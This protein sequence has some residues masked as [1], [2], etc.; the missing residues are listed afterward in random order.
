MFPIKKII[1]SGEDFLFSGDI[2]RFF[3]A[4]FDRTFYNLVLRIS[5]SILLFN[6]IDIIKR[7]EKKKEMQN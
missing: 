2:S 7:R 5:I 4:N 1:F 3:V 6:V